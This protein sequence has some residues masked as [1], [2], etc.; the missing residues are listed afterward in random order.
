MVLMIFTYHVR[1]DMKT[2]TKEPIFLYINNGDLTFTESAAQYGLADKGYGIQAYFFDYD[3]DGDL[4]LYQMNHRLDFNNKNTIM[5]L[6]NEKPEDYDA[7]SR[8]RLYENKGGRFVDV[9]NNAGI[10]NSAWGLSAVMGDFNEDG[11]EDIYVA[12]DYLTPDF[13]YI[14]NQDG[15]FTESIQD[16]FQHMSFFSMGQ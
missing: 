9:S 7:Y 3:R 16:Y 6:R 8:D 14:N 12:N 15:T 11:W 2:Q 13:L 10:F 4:D 5:F 1:V